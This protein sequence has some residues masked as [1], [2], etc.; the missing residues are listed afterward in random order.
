MN[1]LKKLWNKWFKIEE[2]LVYRGRITSF[3]KGDNDWRTVGNS[4][5]ERYPDY[6]YTIGV[7]PFTDNS[8][9]SQSDNTSTFGGGSGGG[10]GASSSWN[11]SSSSSGDGGDD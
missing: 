5:Y 10:A 7:D 11:D 4:S 8:I 2:K 9:P 6:P 1:Y 3:P